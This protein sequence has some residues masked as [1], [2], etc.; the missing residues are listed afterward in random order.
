MP[1]T[2]ATAKAK[3]EPTPKNMENEN[4]RMPETRA[5][6]KAK[7]EPTPEN[8]D[9]ERPQGSVAPNPTTSNVDTD[10][11]I[12]FFNRTLGQTNESQASDLSSRTLA[13]EPAL[14]DRLQISGSGKQTGQYQEI[15][16]PDCPPR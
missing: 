10:G 6:A 4:R 15:L 16:I 2:R 12:H 13:G 7:S 14:E 11:I 9:S 5:T 1:E 3:S 8:M